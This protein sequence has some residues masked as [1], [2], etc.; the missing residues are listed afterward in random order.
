MPLFPKRLVA[1]KGCDNF[2]NSH[3][4]ASCEQLK[5]AETT[6]EGHTKTKLTHLMLAKENCWCI[7]E[8]LT[9]DLVLTSLMKTQWLEVKYRQIMPRNEDILKCENN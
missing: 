7:Q 9:F 2:R 4:Q 5:S 1:T 6:Q 3:S 8:K